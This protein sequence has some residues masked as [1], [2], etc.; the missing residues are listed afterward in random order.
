MKPRISDAIPEYQDGKAVLRIL[1]LPSRDQLHD[2]GNEEQDGQYDRQ[3]HHAGERFAKKI[4]A[5][6]QRQ[7]PDGQ[8][9]NAAAPARGSE[10]LDDLKRPDDEEGPAGQ[11]HGNK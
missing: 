3:R 5:G 2:A 7:H 8:S 4:D 10:A 6:N 9:P 11:L 1:D